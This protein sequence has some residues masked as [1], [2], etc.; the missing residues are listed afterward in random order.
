MK[1]DVAT[2]V[3]SVTRPPSDELHQQVAGVA[4]RRRTTPVAPEGMTWAPMPIK[5]S[6][7]R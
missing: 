7:I 6:V 5:A 1:P 2:V 4:D 3:F